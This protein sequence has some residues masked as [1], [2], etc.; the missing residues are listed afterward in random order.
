[1]KVARGVVIARLRDVST[2]LTEVN[3]P[4]QAAAKVPRITDVDL[5]PASSPP[6]GMA[7][8]R[9]SQGSIDAN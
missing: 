9:S 8:K 7:G 1:M 2:A 3:Q 6:D 5:V 4:G